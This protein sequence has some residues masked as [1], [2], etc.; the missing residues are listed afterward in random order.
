MAYGVVGQSL[1]RSDA[2]AKVT[3]EALY[4]GD[5]R[6]SGCL[7][8]KVLRSPLPH[9]RIL[10]I[11]TSRAERLPGVAT[12]ITA[13]DLPPRRYGHGIADQPVLA[14]DRVLFVGERVA[15]VAAADEATAEEAVELIRVE[16][17]ELP[18][19]TDPLEAMGEGAPVLHPEL[20]SY[21]G[22][23][24]APEAPNV[25]AHVTYGVGDVEAGFR[26]AD[27]VYEDT[28]RT[29]VVHQ[30]Y[31]EPHAC[32]VEIGTAGKV[33]IW[34]TTKSPFEL[35]A[36]LAEL[37]GLPMSSI[38]VHYSYLGGDFG[39]KGAIM[40]EPI[41]YYLALKSGRPVR[42]TMTVAE[43]LTAANPRHAAIITIKSGLKRDGELVARQVRVVFDAGAYAGANTHPVVAGARRALGPYRIPHTR[44]DAYAVYTNSV[45]AGHCRAPG[46]PQVFFAVESHTDM[47]AARLGLDPVEFRRKNLLREGDLSPTGL[48]WEGICALEVMEKA[49]SLSDWGKPKPSPYVGRG[50][51]V[52][53]RTVGAGA[54][55]AVVKLHPDGGATVVTGATDPG[56]GSHTALRQVAAEEL[57]LPVER[58]ALAWGSTGLAPYDQG[59]GSSRVTHVAG[60]AVRLAV[61]DALAQLKQAL[62]ARLGVTAEAITFQ[63]GAFSLPHGQRL[64]LSEALALLGRARNVIIGRGSYVAEE[65]RH[66]C[67]SCQVAEVAVDP[68][69]GYVEVRKVVAVNDIGRAINPAAARGQVEGA[70]V[71]GIGFALTE[72]LPHPDGIPRVTALA[73]YKMLTTLDAPA[74]ESHLLEGALGPGPFGAKSIGEQPIAAAAPA[75][76]NAIYDAVRV[77]LTELP[78]TPEKLRRALKSRREVPEP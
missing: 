57:G 51:A 10:H 9:A 20:A 72:E 43:E 13:K 68:E 61:Q 11:D 65:I 70:V 38:E 29:P 73:D 64:S 56:T 44:I 48:A 60:Q 16:Y 78:I 14:R 59:S 5:I 47:L 74:V 50:L 62:G 28:F 63:D 4:T 17:E 49:L 18:A 40:D 3:G 30:G 32:L 69:T 22:G 66:T 1:P 71:Q 24:R 52:T 58:V 36:H 19:V 46:D 15:A 37:L 45:P 33:R 8:A 34:T 76:A 27:I 31:L 2:L 41:C 6:L 77:R 21:R 12:V 53:E 23:P 67:F 42:L 39:G 55:T 35:R 25:V 75:V 7:E 26:Q 54:S